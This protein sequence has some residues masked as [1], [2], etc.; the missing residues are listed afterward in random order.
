MGNL[1]VKYTLTK[2]VKLPV[3]INRPDRPALNKLNKQG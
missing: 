3:M 1:G 2:K